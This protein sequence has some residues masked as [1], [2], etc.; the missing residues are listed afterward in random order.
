MKRFLRDTYLTWTERHHR[1]PGSLGMAPRLFG[2]VTQP[3]SWLYRAGV[4]V[5]W[6]FNRRKPFPA[7]SNQR[8]AVIASPLVGGV[9]KSP[10]VAHLAHNAIERGCRIAVVTRGYAADQASERPLAVSPDGSNV[11]AVGDEAVMLAQQTRAPVTVARYPEAAIAHLADDASVDLILLDDGVTRRWDGERR[12]LVF[13]ASDLERPI[14][15]L[16]AG[17]W[18]IPPKHALPAHGVAII[19]DLKQ[20]SPERQRRHTA[21]LA[22]WGISLPTGWYETDI[23]G[24]ARPN[25][26]GQWLEMERPSAPPFA[27]C[28]L[29]NPSRFQRSLQS[30]GIE[31]SDVRQFPDHHRYSQ[32]DISNITQSA[33]LAGAEWLLTTHK[34][35][36]KI[37]PAWLGGVPLYILRI[38]L[39]LVH[40]ADMLSVILEKNE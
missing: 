13:T 31:P 21:T 22:S 15:Y 4:G 35:A 29:A 17:R 26:S 11:H 40:G 14:R 39:E 27:F 6:T 10:L 5:S 25:D 9:G 37:P 8:I 1:P 19:Q 16:P 12:I 32:D 30:V 24:F 18:R 23:R 33:R 34:D 7:D 28:G 20:T 38:S 36:V 3:A 2:I